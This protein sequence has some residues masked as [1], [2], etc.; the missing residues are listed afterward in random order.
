MLSD[1]KRENA[2]MEIRNPPVVLIHGMWAKGRCWDR[3]RAHFEARGHEVLSPTLPWHDSAPGDEPPAALAT[4][5]LLD[6]C[7]ALEAEISETL[8][9]CRKDAILIGHSMGGL[10]AQKLAA[11][12]LGGSL[13][14]LAPAPAAGSFP[15]LPE[16][17]RIF[18]PAVL[19]W[20]FHRKVQQPDW[21]AARRAVFNGVPEA[22]ARREFAESVPE[23]G[24][25]LFELG[26]WFLDGENAAMVDRDRIRM[27]VLIV[28]GSEDRI[29]PPAWARAAARGFEGRARYQ[30]L[31]EVGH[32]LIGEPALGRVLARIDRFLET[33]F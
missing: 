7:D 2:A 32:W 12:G 26:F 18:L 15:L 13:I 20:N 19:R 24:R 21:P 17:T 25:V 30:E 29:T 5:S 6:Y 27:P 3:V 9:A 14:C 22:E 4:A 10:L 8:G 1:G 31:A 23:S 28:V 11:R 33:G 16:P